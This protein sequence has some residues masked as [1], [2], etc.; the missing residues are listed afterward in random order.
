MK[1]NTLISPGKIVCV[2]GLGVTGRA[3]VRYCLD[4]GAVVRVSDARIKEQFLEQEGAFIRQHQV[5]WEAGGHS[6][7]FCKECDLLLPSPGVDLRKEPFYSLEKAGTKIAGELAVVAGEIKVPVVAVTGTNGKTTVTSLIGEVLK[8]SGK[9][10]F[11]GGNIGTPLYEFC[12]LMDGYDVVVA[13][14][15]SFQL[16]TSG[17]F[18]PDIGILLNI[19]PDHLDR[20]ETIKEYIAAKARMFCNQ[21]A[22]GVGVING[23]DPCCQQLVLPPGVTAI[24]FGK[25]VNNSLQITDT[26]FCLIEKEGLRNEFFHGLDTGGGFTAYN[27]AAAYAALNKLGLT[28]VEIAKGFAEFSSLP[29][30]LEFVAEKDKVVFINDSKATNTGAVIGALEEMETGVVLIAGGRGK[31]EDYSLLRKSVA[32]KVH[33][34]VLIGEAAVELK[35]CLCD[36]TLCIDARDMEDAVNKAYNAA[37]HGDTVLLSPACASFDMFKSYGHRG[38]VFRKV[39]AALSE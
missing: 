15:S 35:K 2:I 37:G 36:V 32:E 26:S 12:H 23:D 17:D 10:V 22:T 24:T 16:E 3:A 25:G 21:S 11:V 6:A 33:T 18:A 20:H 29:N 14:V 7:D 34:L 5:E 38:D 8:K 27:Y 19:T 28:P 4:R 30:R 1:E 9:R 31:G 13:E 39:V